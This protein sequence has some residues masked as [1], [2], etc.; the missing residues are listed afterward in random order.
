MGDFLKRLI[1][2]NI[3]YIHINEVLNLF[4]INFNEDEKD[5]FCQLNCNDEPPFAINVS[6]SAN[7]F[8][9]FFFRR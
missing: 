9:M 2:E 3:I 5:A 1:A 8:S 6:S 4:N 7:S